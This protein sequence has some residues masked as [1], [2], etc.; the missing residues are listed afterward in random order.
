MVGVVCLVATD[1]EMHTNSEACRYLSM[2]A[3]GSNLSTAFE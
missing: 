3:P 2:V 1:G